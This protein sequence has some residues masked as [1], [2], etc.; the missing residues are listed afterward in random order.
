MLSFG[1]AHHLL[2]VFHLAGEV[3]GWNWNDV[4]LVIP[5]FKESA[6]FVVAQ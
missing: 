4:A 2:T 3:V 6:L 5:C 1:P